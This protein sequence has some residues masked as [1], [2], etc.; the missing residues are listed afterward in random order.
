MFVKALG[1]DF[2]NILRVC[3]GNVISSA[4]QHFETKT[5]L[6]RSQARTPRVA[7]CKADR[8]MQCYV[9]LRIHIY[10]YTKCIYIYDLLLV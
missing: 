2:R 10:I 1:L 5:S 9:R 4:D 7:I 6:R 8:F 3:F